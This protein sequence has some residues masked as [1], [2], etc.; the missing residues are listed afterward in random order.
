MAVK[1]VSNPYIFWFSIFL[2]C[3]IVALLL[4]I[5]PLPLASNDPETARYLLSALMQSQAAIIAIVITLT[6]IAVQVTAST[7]SASISEVIKEYPHT[8]ILLLS[9]VISISYDI[10]FLNTI[11]NS[12]PIQ[13]LLNFSIY[14]AILLF[15]PL[16]LYIRYTMFLMRVGPLLDLLSRRV[17]NEI[18]SDKP[19]INGNSNDAFNTYFDILYAT[20]LKYD[21]PTLNEGFRIITDRFKQI[22]LTSLDSEKQKMLYNSLFRKMMT[23]SNIACKEGNE[24]SMLIIIK[25]FKH[26]CDDFLKED[27]LVIFTHAWIFLEQL[28]SVSDKQ[29]FSVA[30]EMIWAYQST[31]REN[32]IFSFHSDSINALK[33]FYYDYEYLDIMQ[34]LNIIK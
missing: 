33:T 24:E 30:L 16:A 4:S 1:S 5:Y 20:I 21:A 34:H 25:N 6:L 3:V 18:L 23:C 9:Y 11:T 10:W 27:N 7:Y 15:F 26:I 2:A 14:Y 19:E 17:K 22:Y 32:E 28:K 13:F 12:L 8:W 29:G 31:I